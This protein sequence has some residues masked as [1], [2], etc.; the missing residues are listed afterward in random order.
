MSGIQVYLNKE[1]L[2]A[3]EDAGILQKIGISGTKMNRFVS[4]AVKYYI[5][6][7]KESQSTLDDVF[8]DIIE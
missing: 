5:K 3:M 1:T 2:K 8:Q 7:L 6:Y 4:N